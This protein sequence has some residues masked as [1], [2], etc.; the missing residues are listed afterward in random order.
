MRPRGGNPPSRWLKPIASM[1]D[2][3]APSCQLGMSTTAN[4]FAI[5]RGRKWLRQAP[6]H[7]RPPNTPRRVAGATL[8]AVPNHFN[9]S[10]TES[11]LL[12]WRGS[13]TPKLQAPVRDPPENG[14]GRL[15]GYSRLHHDRDRE[16][17]PGLGVF[18]PDR[19]FSFG[20]LGR[21][22]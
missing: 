6:D 22:D 21:S 10:D 15:S 12:R 2:C 14:P 13:R 19:C 9:R 4:I 7:L 1:L 5:R 20:A 8:T 17:S 11:L 3:R 16:N 18:Q